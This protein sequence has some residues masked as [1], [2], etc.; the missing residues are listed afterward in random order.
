MDNKTILITRL[1]D[2]GLET[3]GSMS[4]HGPSVPLR[5]FSILELAWKDNTQDVSC[6][7]AGKYRGFIRYSNKYGRHIHIMG[8][9]GRGL[10]LIHWGNFNSDTLG[11][12]LIGERFKDIDGDGELDVTSSKDSFKAF[13]ASFLDT[14]TI[15]IEITP[16][17]LNT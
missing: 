1:I 10:I 2:N 4:V 12:V 7:P 17:I 8:V 16:A 5:I 6:I 11:C 14:D 15:D 9:S 13:M 3:L